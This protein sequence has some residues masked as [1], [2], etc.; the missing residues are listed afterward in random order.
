MLRWPT[1]FARLLI[2]MLDVVCLAFIGWALHVMNSS[3]GTAFIYLEWNRFIPLMC[4]ALFSLWLCADQMHHVFL[5]WQTARDLLA[6][7]PVFLGLSTGFS[8][9]LSQPP[10]ALSLVATL[11]AISVSAILLSRFFWLFCLRWVGHWAMVRRKVVIVGTGRVAQEAAR[12]LSEKPEYGCLVSGFVSNRDDEIGRLLNGIPIIGTFD[13][14]PALVESKAELVLFCL[15]PQLESC[16]ET[17]LHALKNTTVDVKL[18][19]SVACMETVPMEAY[20]FDGL[21]ILT[22]QGSPVHGWHAAG[23]RAVDLAGSVAG[24]CLASPL[25][26]AI[27]ILVKTSSPGPVLYRQV[28]MSLAGRPFVMLKFRTMHEQAERNTGPIWAVANDA[29]TTHIG[30]LLRKAS[31]DELPQLWNVLRGDMSLVGPRPERPSYIETFRQAYPTYMLRHTVK[32][33]MTGWAQI[34]GWR[35]NTCIQERIAHDLYYIQHWSL[36]FDV[37]ILC[38]TVW[39]GVL[40]ENAY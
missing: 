39:K 13:Q 40:H 32:A 14:L 6:A 28:R 2:L 33:G 23:K 31:L 10:P 18:V 7:M 25:F 26:L 21:P 20:L 38:Q 34:N 1:N 4:L 22:L 12:R 8:S 3:S 15:P 5:T 36:W 16:T 29:R 11:W 19:P 37:K 17:L 30:R 24:L 9:V 35:G 27:A